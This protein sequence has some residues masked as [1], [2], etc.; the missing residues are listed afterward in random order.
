MTTINMQYWLGANERTHVLP[1]DKW[2]LDFATSILPLVKTSP[3]FNKEDLRTQIDAA[4]SLGMYF[5]D[6][7]AQSGG[8]KLFSEAFQGVYGT[9]L[10]FYPLGD[11]YTPDEINQEDI[12]FVLW[13]LKSQFSIFD[14]E[15]TL[16]SPYDKDL[17]ALSQSA[18]E[19]MD[20]RFEEAPISEGESSFLWVMGLDLLDMP[21]TPLPEV[22]PE[23]KLSKDAARCLEYSQ[24]KPLLYF[25]DY[26]ELCTFFVDVLGWENKRSALLP[27]LEYQKEFVIYANAKGML[28]AHNVAAY[29]CEEHNPMYDAKRAA[30]EGYKM[31]CQPGYAHYSAAGS[32]SGNQTEQ[33]CRPLS[34]IQPGETAAILHRLQGALHFLCRCLGMG[35][36]TVRIIARPGIPK[37]VRDLC[38]RQ[39]YARSPQRGRLFL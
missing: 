33:R 29:F 8:W 30:A 25:T 21:I 32:H 9:Y 37:R 31:F 14:K 24:G 28:V 17:L 13:T 36:Q 19:L 7:I 6:A 16:F 10:P 26:K 23:T 22:T 27:D 3:L 38:Q 35:K 5:Q 4:I 11:D 15:Y 18:Y 20:A 12:A 34:G 39:R 1:T 2:Y